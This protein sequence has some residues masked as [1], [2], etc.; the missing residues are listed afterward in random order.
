MSSAATVI[1]FEKQSEKLTGRACGAACL[2]MVYRSLGKPVEQTAIWPAISKENRF[3]RISSTTYLMT[4]DAINR[5]FR[6]VAIQA[7]NPLD[8]L[9]L[10]S[11]RGIR[12][13]LNHRAQADS[14]AGHYTVLV[15]IDSKDVILHDPLFGAARR[16]P[17]AQLLDLWMPQIANSEIVGGV[18]IAVGMPAEAETPAC[19]F[20]HT[21]MLRSIDCPRCGKPTC[22]EPGAVL[23]CMRDGC[24]AR[25]WNWVCCP[26][27]DCVF[28]MKDGQAAGASAAAPRPA[29]AGANAPA[30]PS[31]DLAKLFGEIDK[32]TSQIRSMPGTADNPDI[33]K[34]LD[35]IEATKVDI[36]AA[37]AADLAR[38][39]AVVGQLAA[40]E[41]NNKK[42]NEEQLKKAED[43]KAPGPP[44]DGD[45]IGNAMLKNLGFTK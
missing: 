45:A 16:L 3:G 4:Q 21:P 10:C 34:R 24:I 23:A 8:A 18:L 41:E 43:R 13:I 27:C 5:G 12:A 42:Q 2:S 38:R 19:E 9:R 29:A 1:P 31:V 30:V 20:C 36:K 11:A 15:D 39:T 32:F 26:A 44:L 25:M 40:F 7:R 17:H 22:L 28:S 37:H 35:F 14:S 6:A 33:K